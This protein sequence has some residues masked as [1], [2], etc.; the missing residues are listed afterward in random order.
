[1]TATDMTDD[2]RLQTSSSSSNRI[3][4]SKSM[5]EPIRRIRKERWDERGYWKRIPFS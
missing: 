5:N 3:N 2:R 4:D 1:M